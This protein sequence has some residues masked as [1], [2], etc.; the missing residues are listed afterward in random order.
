MKIELLSPPED[1]FVVGR[2]LV[3]FAKVGNE[4]DVWEDLLDVSGAF[5][6]KRGGVKVNGLDVGML[7]VPVKDVDPEGDFRFR[8]GRHIRL[9]DEDRGNVLWYGRTYDLPATDEGD[10]TVTTLA[11]TDVLDSLAN[12]SRYGAGT[13]GTTESLKSRVARLAASASVSLR[14]VEESAEFEGLAVG[15]PVAVPTLTGHRYRVDYEYTYVGTPLGPV[16]RIFA[17]PV[18]G[19]YGSALLPQSS[20]PSAPIQAGFE[21]TAVGLSTELNLAR[22]PWFGDVPTQITTTGLKVTRIEGPAVLQAVS[23]EGPISE[24]LD[25]ACNSVGAV[26]RPTLDG[27]V[28]V[29]DADLTASEPVAWFTDDPHDPNTAVSFTK[30]EMGF[31]AT[32]DLIN[33]LSITNHGPGADTTRAYTNSASIA[34]HGRRSATLET[35]LATEPLVDAL[36]ARLLNE[37]S[38]PRWVPRSVTVLYD[39]LDEVPDLYST[40]RV[41]RRGVTHLCQVLGLEHEVEPYRH[42]PTGRKH[43]VSLSLRKVG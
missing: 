31:A 41:T 2:D 3:G 28:E 9:Y 23:Y 36:A 34:A 5:T 4:P 39:H 1:S 19:S 32:E 37:S 20:T 12:T 40:V 22:A 11:G 29:F 13:P 14:Y 6:A 27:A 25:M 43:S 15:V 17:G 26:W 38:T 16:G 24:H 35:C 7:S 30:I 21:F 18:G 10:Y 42:H 8:V 33:D